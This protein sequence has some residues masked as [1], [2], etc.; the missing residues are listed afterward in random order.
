MTSNDLL[1]DHLPKHS[2]SSF[3]RRPS[4]ADD[5]QQAESS[6]TT[7]SDEEEDWADAVEEQQMSVE[8]MQV[9]CFHLG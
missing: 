1:F 9:G 8:E 7:A 2:S 5:V 4:W 6:S 3:G